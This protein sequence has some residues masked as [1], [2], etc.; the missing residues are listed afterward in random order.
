MNLRLTPF[1]ALKDR[2]KDRGHARNNKSENSFRCITEANDSMLPIDNIKIKTI[3][4]NPPYHDRAKIRTPERY[5][6]FTRQ[7]KSLGDTH[8]FSGKPGAEPFYISRKSVVTPARKMRDTSNDFSKSRE[9][10]YNQS[11]LMPTMLSS[12]QKLQISHFLSNDI[13]PFTVKK[14]RDNRKI[15]DLFP[16]FSN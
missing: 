7:R 16:G 3:I 4:I 11:Q 8:S 1:K 14:E 6:T 5:S 10:E 15:S 2:G 12:K 13:K 9:K